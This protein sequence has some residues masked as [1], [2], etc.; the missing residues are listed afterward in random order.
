MSL[1]S[2]LGKDPALTPAPSREKNNNNKAQCLCCSLLTPPTP[3]SQNTGDG[4]K[5]LGV[6]RPRHNPRRGYVE[7][8]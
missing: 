8:T 7:K 4:C 6:Q 2:P 1:V 3:G 5:L